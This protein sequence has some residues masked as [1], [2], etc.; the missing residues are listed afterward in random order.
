MKE[1]IVVLA[2]LSFLLSFFVYWYIES[3]TGYDVSPEGMGLIILKKIAE[4]GDGLL[5]DPQ[6]RS[7]FHFVLWVESF[8]LSLLG[9]GLT[10]G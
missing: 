10:I 2:I 9:V 8:A 1:L 3:K 4:V 7:S 5:T 6:A